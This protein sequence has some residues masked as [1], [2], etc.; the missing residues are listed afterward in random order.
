[1]K[2]KLLLPFLTALVLTGCSNDDAP[3]NNG[4]GSANGE[5]SYLAVNIV[6]PKDV[7]GR[8]TTEGGF[9][10]GTDDE[11]AASSATF[12]LLDNNNK[13]FQVSKNV[14][15][16]LETTNT[17]TPVTNVERIS[18]AIIVVDGVNEKPD[19]KGILAILNAPS[20]LD[21]AK[22]TDLSTITAT[23]D[24]YAT[25]ES[26]SAGKFIMSNSVYINDADN[27]TIAEAITKDAFQTTEDLAKK[28]SINIHVERVVA[29]VRTKAV[30]NITDAQFNQG[31]QV[32]LFEDA[33]KNLT[34][35]IKGIQIAN[36]AT[37]SYLFKDIN[38]LAAT[39]NNAPW[40]GW[41]EATN[42]RCYWAAKTYAFNPVVSS[43]FN[44]NSWY[45][46]SGKDNN[47]TDIE[48][49]DGVVKLLTAPHSF[50][51]Q[52]NINQTY[53]TSVI[54]TAQLKDG[55][56]P[57][58]LVRIGGLYFT[59]ENGLKHIAS[60]LAGHSYKVK[61]GNDPIK[62][63]DY[64]C[65]D[66]KSEPLTGKKAWTGYAQ[67]KKD[68]ETTAKF[69]IYDASYTQDANH[70]KP[71]TLDDMNN[72]LKEPQYLA[73]YWKNGMC[74]YYAE[75]EHFG[76]EKKDGK[77]VNRNGIIRNHIYDITLNK[78]YGLG[79]PVIEPDEPIIPERPDD[80]ETL[81]YLAAKVNILSW[82]VVSQGV[83]LH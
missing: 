37:K 78:I 27:I 67:I 68:L 50:Y 21:F 13:V 16:T 2:T 22:G 44:N 33:T 62:D 4:G 75:I 81:F 71:C 43:D 72:V 17:G 45:A 23:L 76:K 79:V 28:N 42:K 31:A 59:L 30:T 24:N 18:S 49:G 55:D 5:T 14:A 9:E 51:V 34:I 40:E 63:F 11:N 7:M 69:Y 46:I 15:L 39:G 48:T 73:L 54:V 80:D 41:N 64:T 10:Y 61:I 82:K 36:C 25:E 74:Y 12:I 32:E 66:W 53:K 26:T 65:I 56:Q 57:F 38:G 77:D 83:D 70:L 1:M 47:G 20:S 60:I 8:A 6:T 35:D 19:I 3:D 58:A 29:K 52:E